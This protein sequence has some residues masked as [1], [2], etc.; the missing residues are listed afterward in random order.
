MN[1]RFTYNLMVVFM[2]VIVSIPIAVF[3][4]VLVSILIT[5]FM[6]VLISNL[7]AVFM[8]DKSMHENTKIFSRH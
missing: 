8:P 4:H 3:M 5:V 1:K 2:H 7:I 6:H